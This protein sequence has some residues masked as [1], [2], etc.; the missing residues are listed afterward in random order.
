MAGAPLRGKRSRAG[1]LPA[2]CPPC[3]RLCK[4]RS[5]PSE[6]LLGL[7]PKPIIE[8]WGIAPLALFT[9]PVAL[10]FIPHVALAALFRSGHVLTPPWLC[11]W[12][13]ARCLRPPSART[14]RTARAPAALAVASG[15]M[16]GLQARPVGRHSVSTFSA[17]GAPGA[18]L[19][20]SAMF[21]SSRERGTLVL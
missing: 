8:L 11:V 12:L 5:S 16:R 1:P 4:A 13:R 7:A 9:P 21:S 18:T 14:S 2:P 15:T 20:A 17:V 10:V 6:L 19:A 3:G